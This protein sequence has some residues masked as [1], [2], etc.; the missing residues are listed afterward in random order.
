LGNKELPTRSGQRSRSNCSAGSHFQYLLV[1][2][3][4][5]YNAFHD[6]SES[7]KWKMMI[8]QQVSHGR[9]D[10]DTANAAARRLR[11]LTKGPH[12]DVEVCYEEALVENFIGV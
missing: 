5:L 8:T 1:Y 7:L 12:L 3:L 6:D 10:V 4:K 9:V 2:A 11:D